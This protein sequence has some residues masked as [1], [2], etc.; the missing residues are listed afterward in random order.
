[1]TIF[2]TMMIAMSATALLGSQTLAAEVSGPLAAGKPAGIREAQGSPNLLIAL[3]AIV[4]VAGAVG[5]ALAMD[6]KSSCGAS[7]NAPAVSTTP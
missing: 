7:C 5:I 2:R 6:D 3:G 4:V 1:M